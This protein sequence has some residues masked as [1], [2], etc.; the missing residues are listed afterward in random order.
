MD[1]DSLGLTD[2]YGDDYVAGLD[3]ERKTG[4]PYF[5]KWDWKD[6]SHPVGEHGEVYKDH[7]AR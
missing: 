4:A 3:M 6:G 5:K 7:V 1:T 2:P